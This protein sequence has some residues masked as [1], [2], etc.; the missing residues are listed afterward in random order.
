MLE[1]V[2]PLLIE[3]GQNGDE[4]A[5]GSSREPAGLR[6]CELAPF[7]STW[8]RNGPWEFYGH[9]YCLGHPLG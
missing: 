8:T 5:L 7:P 3:D 4:A 1:N 6:G 9:I 2:E